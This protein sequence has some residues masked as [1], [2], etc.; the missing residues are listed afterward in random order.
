MDIPLLGVHREA[1]V[2]VAFVF[3]LARVSVRYL[4]PLPW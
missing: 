4:Q 3:A 2:I 1:H